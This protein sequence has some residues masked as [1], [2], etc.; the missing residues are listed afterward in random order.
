LGTVVNEEL[1][2]GAWGHI[3]TFYISIDEAVGHRSLGNTPT[4]NNWEIDDI[5]F[6]PTTATPEPNPIALV[7]I[8]SVLGFGVHLPGIWGRI[9]T[10]Y[11]L[12]FLLLRFFQTAPSAE[13]WI[14]DPVATY[15]GARR[16]GASVKELDGQR[17]ESPVLVYRL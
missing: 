13:M 14:V 12:N 3:S 4:V 8:G 2:E 16:I 9:S 7:G 11:I 15:M 6:S 5:S 17:R 1:D 10:F